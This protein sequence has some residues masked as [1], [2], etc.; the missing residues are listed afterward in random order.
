MDNF[1]NQARS[2]AAQIMKEIRDR[3]INDADKEAQKIIVSAIQRTATD[4][5]VESTVTVVPIP[6]DEMKGRIIGRE[7]PQ[8]PG[9]RTSHRGWRSSWTIRRTR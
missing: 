7:G 6:S 5:S 8:Y 3:A 4:H 1:I 9:F 2:D